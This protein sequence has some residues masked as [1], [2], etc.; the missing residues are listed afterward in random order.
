MAAAVAK[1]PYAR[2]PERRAAEILRA[3]FCEGRETGAAEANA[4]AASR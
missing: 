1:A 4:A 3:K 2:E